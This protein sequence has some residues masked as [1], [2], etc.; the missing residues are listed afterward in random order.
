MQLRYFWFL[1]SE[2]FVSTENLLVIGT[3]CGGCRASD[4][5]VILRLHLSVDI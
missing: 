2:K 4:L 5:L 1:E 3:V